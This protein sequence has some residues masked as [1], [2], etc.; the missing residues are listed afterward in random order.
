[1]NT[2]DIF[3]F[4]KGISK[5]TKQELLT[6]YLQGRISKQELD[7][8]MKAIGYEL[9]AIPTDICLIFRIILLN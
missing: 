3:D 7:K 6:K 2:S 5:P 4:F 1:M 9:H 8:Q